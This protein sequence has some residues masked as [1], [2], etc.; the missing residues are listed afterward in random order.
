MENKLALKEMFSAGI[1][2]VKDFLAHSSLHYEHDYEELWLAPVE[3]NTCVRHALGVLKRADIQPGM[4]VLD[5]GC[6]NGF[7]LAACKKMGCRVYG[8]D[9]DVLKPAIIPPIGVLLR[10]SFGLYENVLHSGFTPGITPVK[11]NYDRVIFTN[12]T[13]AGA[14]DESAHRKAKAT[15]I[16]CTNLGGLLYVSL[17]PNQVDEKYDAVWEEGAIGTWPNRAFLL[18]RE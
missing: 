8:I 13:G 18:R 7:L 15:L 16:G 5:I 1:Q 12:F 2:R 9:L 11:A 6:R 4:S 14:W 17:M 10:I 3:S